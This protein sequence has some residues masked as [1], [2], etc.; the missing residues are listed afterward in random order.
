MPFMA[1]ATVYLETTVLSYVTARDARDVVVAAH[2][3]ANL[4]GESAR[5][6][7]LGG[8]RDRGARSRRG[9][10]RVGG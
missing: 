10:S 8:F 3:S 4:V 9:R 2:Q 5:T 7:S 1:G 6:V